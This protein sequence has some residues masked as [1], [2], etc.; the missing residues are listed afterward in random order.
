MGVSSV[1]EVSMGKRIL[2]ID[3]DEMVLYAMKTIFEDLG[4]AVNTTTDPVEGIKDA[5]VNNYDLIIAD[6]RM[7]KRNGAEVVDAVL[8]KKPGTRILIV[9]SHPT[10]PLVARA[11]KAGA[12]GLIKKP[13]EVMKILEFL[14]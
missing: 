7:P 1:Q 10:D 2:A 14:K 11:L 6:I 12:V 8:A 9:T 13:F 5:L 4:Y 3:D